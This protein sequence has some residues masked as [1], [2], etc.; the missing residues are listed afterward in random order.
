MLFRYALKRV[1]NQDVAEDLVQETFVSAIRSLNSFQGR[2]TV[3]TWLVG[4][5]RNKIVDHMRQQGRKKQREEVHRA[6]IFHNGHWQVGLRPWSTD[7]SASLESEEFW[8][9]LDQCFQ[10]L[11]DKLAIAFRMRDL[12]QLAMPEICE[13]LEI[14]STNLS[15]RLH[16]ARLLLRECLDQNWFS[17][18]KSK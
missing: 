10:K 8:H 16:R 12:E 4:I 15:V 3:Q 2:S 5:L 13:V 17:A 18:R 9:V 6:E 7:P 1:G 11:P 14:T